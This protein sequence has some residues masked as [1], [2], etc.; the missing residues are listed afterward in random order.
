M[1]KMPQILIALAYFYNIKLFHVEHSTKFFRLFYVSRGTYTAQILEIVDNF[2]KM[3]DFLLIFTKIAEFYVD[4]Y[5][6]FLSKY[7]NNPLTE[8]NLCIFCG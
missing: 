5:P 7:L 6:R 2:S 8:V 1:S 4:N 3:W